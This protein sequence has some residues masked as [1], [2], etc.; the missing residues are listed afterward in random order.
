MKAINTGNVYTLYDDSMKT[1]D[2]LPAQVYTVCFHPQ[3]GFWLEKY[4]DLEIKEK[5]YG[6]H[7]LKTEKVFRSFELTNRN[8]GVILS[9]DKGIGKSLFAKKLSIKAVE[10]GYPL[11]IVDAYIPGIANFLNNIEQEVVVLFD[12]F[13]KTF[14]GGRDNRDSASDPQ[15]EMLSLFDGISMGKKLFIVTCNELRNLNDYLVNRP[16]RFHYH[17]RFEYPQAEE[18]REY[19]QDKLDKSYWKEIDEVIGFSKKIKLNY[20]CLR[21]IA[22]ELSMGFTFKDAICDLNIVNLEREEYDIY[23]YFEDGTRLARKNY[24][25]DLFSD[26]ECSIDFN[27]EKIYDLVELKFIP[28]DNNYDYNYGGCAIKAENLK[29]KISDYYINDTEEDKK[30]YER[31]LNMKPAYLLIKRKLNKGIHYAV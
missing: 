26:E 31:F 23:L 1:F 13:D 16:G 18:I 17:F 29:I 12:E 30:I 7:N 24:H 27:Y 22:F 11:I 15:T 19:L 6:V 14:N 21:A 3:K 28:S 4:S 20:D 5:T 8:M 9:G 10:N 25:M 2:Q